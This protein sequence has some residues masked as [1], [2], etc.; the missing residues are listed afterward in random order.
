[1]P[2][3]APV[4]KNRLQAPSKG[5]QYNGQSGWGRNTKAAA[6]PSAR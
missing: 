6:G 2:L 3:W 4:S 1:V 5:L